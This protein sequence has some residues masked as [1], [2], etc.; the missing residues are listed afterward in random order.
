MEEIACKVIVG[1]AQICEPREVAQLL[2]D[3]ACA[4][5][6]NGL[7]L[8]SGET[9]V[10]CSDSVEICAYLRAYCCKETA[11][12]GSAALPAPWGCSLS[13]FGRRRGKGRSDAAGGASVYCSDSVEIHF[14]GT[15][16]T[17][18]ETSRIGGYMQLRQQL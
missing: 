8:H 17:L 18:L 15:T 13:D 4:G 16:S 11:P 6:K 12:R 7:E 14:I 3:M 2:R 5:R 9:S 10:Y 1:E